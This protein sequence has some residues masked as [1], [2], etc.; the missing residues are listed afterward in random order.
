MSV[1][2]GKI[3]M[4]IKSFKKLVI[5]LVIISMASVLGLY[6]L[7]S[8]NTTPIQLSNFSWVNKAEIY[9]MGI[10]MSAIAYPIY[11]EIAQEHMMLYSPFEEDPR[12]IDDGF[13]LHSTVAQ[14]AIKKAKHLKRPYRLAWPASTYRLSFNPKAYQE[15]RVALALNGGYLRVEDNK[16]IVRIKIAY[17]RKSYAPLIPIPGYGSIGVEEGL[18]WILQQEGWFHEGYVEWVAA[19]PS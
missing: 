9:V 6:R 1:E 19:L 10:A 7:H 11:P 13:F 18:F 12:I 3:Q 17:P 8:L 16:A 4:T 14:D 2:S 5:A 15:A